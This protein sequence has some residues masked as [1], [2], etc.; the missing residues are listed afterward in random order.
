MKR[1]LFVDDEINIL[2]GTKRMLHADRSRWEMTFVLSAEAALRAFEE[3]GGFDVIV[4]DMLMP[5][6]DGT[7]LLQTVR[8]R[9]PETARLILSGYAETSLATRAISVA[10]QLINKPCQSVE[11]RGAI[12]RVCTLQDVLSTPELRAVVG[13][14]SSLPSLSKTYDALAC[15]VRDPST[16]IEIVVGIVEQDIAMSAKILHLV[17]SAFFGLAQKV[18]QIDVAIRFLGI[19]IIRNI[20]L[21]SEAFTVFTPG[22]SCPKFLLEAIQEQAHRAAAIVKS[23]GLGHKDHDVAIIAAL[24]HDIGHLILACK[25]PDRF[26]SILEMAEARGC[27]CLEVEEELLGISHAEIGAYLLG[28]WGIDSR[29]VESIAYHHRPTKI[30]HT[31]LDAPVAVY[32]ADLLIH[33]IDKHPTDLRGDQLSETDRASLCTLAL[34]EKYPMF[35]EQALQSLTGDASELRCSHS[36]FADCYSWTVV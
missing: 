35:R 27:S 1:I 22:P 34:M 31:R 5:G 6:M 33:E 30:P 28:L 19:E 17:N 8:D 13:T 23:F 21:T 4:S 32:L 10:H 11:L 9:Y 14:I 16:T 15:A 25:M 18:T 24:L 26:C 2:E 36:K 29:V 20:A 12:E 3:K 7:E